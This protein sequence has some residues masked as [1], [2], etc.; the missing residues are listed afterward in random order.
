MGDCNVTGG[1]RSDRWLRCCIPTIRFGETFPGELKVLQ[2]D[3]DNDIFRM[4]M[5]R[6]KKNMENFGKLLSAQ[7]LKNTTDQ[8]D[9]VSMTPCVSGPEQMYSLYGLLSGGFREF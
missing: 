6:R 1:L 4:K 9:N 2:N 3:V 5:L 8:E 7:N